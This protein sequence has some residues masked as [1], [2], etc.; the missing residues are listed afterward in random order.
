MNSLPKVLVIIH[1]NS[2]EAEI[3]ASK[4]CKQLL[5]RN[6]FSK[7]DLNRKRQT[8]RSQEVQKIR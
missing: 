3:V 6:T 1:N 5:E 2:S 8:T 7:E 4:V